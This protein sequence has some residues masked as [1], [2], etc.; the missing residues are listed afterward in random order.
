MVPTAVVP[1]AMATAMVSTAVV[2]TAMVVAMVATATAPTAVVPTITAN[3]V[4]PTMKRCQLDSHLAAPAGGHHRAMQQAG[5]GGDGVAFA[6]E[7]GGHENK[8]YFGGPFP[9]VFG[10]PESGHGPTAYVLQLPTSGR[11]GATD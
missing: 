9:P 11:S 6:A 4:V 2:P 7:N 8:G 3:S 1:T 10:G 5:N